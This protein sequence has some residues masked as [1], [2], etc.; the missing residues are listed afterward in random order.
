MSQW[1]KLSGWMRTW[2]EK[3]TGC[4]VH[5]LL[6]WVNN[7]IEGDEFQTFTNKTAHIMSSDGIQVNR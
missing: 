6:L 4:M 5:W 2:G 3:Y 1:E 7:V